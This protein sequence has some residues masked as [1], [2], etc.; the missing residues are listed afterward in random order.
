MNNPQN[1]WRFINSEPSDGAMNMAVDVAMTHSSNQNIRPTLRFYQWNPFAISLGFHQSEKDID[2]DKC[3]DAGIDV[4]KRPT[5]GRAILHA[6]ELTYS[7]VLPNT[8]RFYSPEILPVY[9][10]I[11]NCIM[12]GLKKLDITADFERAKK[13][14]EN[15]SRG[16]LSSLCYASSVQYEIALK[17]K[18]LVG[19]AQRR[20]DDAVLQHGSI[21]IGK[22][23]LDLPLFL[24]K[25]DDKWRSAVRRYMEK[26]TICLEDIIGTN[27]DLEKLVQAVKQGFAET[28]QVEF[29]QEDLTKFEL[30]TAKQM[31][32][33]YLVFSG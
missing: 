9:D 22:R 27:L 30:E 14:P 8:S 17:D 23:H 25:G 18:K 3:K 26:N 16:E 12:A 5:G 15:F 31:R 1:V 29:E 11:S 6:V 2:T 33:K 7:V 19:S 10:L 21:L 24:T 32:E 4:V 28:L 20:F 13:T